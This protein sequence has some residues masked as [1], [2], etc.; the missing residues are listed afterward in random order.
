M[1]SSSESSIMELVSS[2]KHSKTI[3][4]IAHRLSTIKNADKVIYLDSGKVM[5]TGTFDQLRN[6]VPDFD[7]QV[8][9]QNLDLG[10]ILE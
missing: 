4:L 5:G 3:I 6:I 9:R 8:V 7:N 2:Y 10:E 1:D